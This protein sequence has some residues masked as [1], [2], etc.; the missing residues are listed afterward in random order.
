M[1]SLWSKFSSPRHLV[2]FE[3]AARLGS[4]TVAA[5][6]LNVQQPSVSA[7]IKQLEQ[8]LGVQLFQ[9]NHR[10]IVLT[11]A[12]NRLFADVQRSFDLLAQSAA[13]LQQSVS[14]DHVT[15]S[16]SSAFNN[17][18]MLPRLS[19][20]HQQHPDIDLRLQSSDREPDLRAE[21]ISLAVRLG[22]GDWPG[23][24]CRLIA[25][26]VIYPVASP[27]VMAA[28]VGLRNI[29]GLLHQ[30][31]IHLEE[32]IRERPSWNQWFQEF[33]IPERPSP[34]GLRL[35]DYALVLQA[36]MAGEGFAFGWDHLVRPLVEDDLLASLP[37]WSWKTGKSFYLVWSKDV[38]LIP[39]AEIVRDW[40]LGS[41]D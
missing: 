16:A 27:R 15:F 33:G 3:A 11:N 20:F 22:T 40:I 14:N 41:L 26:E 17:Y 21:P 18:W 30:R 5:R 19:T 39:K 4:F 2:V 23:Y 9:R 34:S 31:L 1:Q 38:P 29:T 10:S 13:A 8:S 7:S 37:K 6:E 36:A 12:G 32:P 25:E 24:E 28:A 35:N